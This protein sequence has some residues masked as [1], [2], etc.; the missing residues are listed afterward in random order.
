MLYIFIPVSLATV[1]LVSS[2]ALEKTT[3]LPPPGP[4][5][6]EPTVCA[7]NQVPFSPSKLIDI[8][9]SACDR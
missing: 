3:G 6:G 9:F 5:H 8:E 2:S 1:K 7:L 4:P